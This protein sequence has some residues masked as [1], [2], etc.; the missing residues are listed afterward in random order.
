VS[1]LRIII[2]GM[3]SKSGADIESV[4]R[5]C[6][7]EAVNQT[8]EF[9]DFRQRLWSSSLSGGYDEV[10]AAALAAVL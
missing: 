7:G 8:L 5:R 1:A 3:D 10:P 6:L 9:D 4:T 2:E